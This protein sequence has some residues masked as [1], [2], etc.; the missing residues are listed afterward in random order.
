MVEQVLFTEDGQTGLT[1]VQILEQQKVV[2]AGEHLVIPPQALRQSLIHLVVRGRVEPERGLFEDSYHLSKSAH[3]EL[4]AL[5]SQSAQ[6]ID[7]VVGRLFQYAAEASSSYS[8]PFLDA[9]CRV[10][11]ILTETYVRVLIGKARPSDL[12]T[13]AMLDDVIAEVQ[14]THPG[15]EIGVFRAALTSFFTEEDP[16][17][18][19]IKWNLAQSYYLAKALGLDP[20]GKLLSMEVL[21]G[22]E[23]YLDTNIII[24][25]LEPRARHH[26]S[27]RALFSI[28]KR[29]GIPLCVCQ[30]SLDQ[31]RYVTAANVELLPRAAPQIPAATSAKVPSIFY[32]MYKEEL[33]ATGTVDFSI[34][35]EQFF[36]PIKPLRENCG[37]ELLDDNWFT[38]ASL[39]SQVEEAAEQLNENLVARKRLRKAQK[40]AIHDAL[41][42]LWITKQRSE[43]KT[44]CWLVTLDTSFSDTSWVPG[45]SGTF[46]LTL[47]ALLQWLSPLVPQEDSSFQTSYA[48]AVKQMVLPQDRIFE[49][50]D[51]LIFSDMA[52]EVGELPA[53]DVEACIRHLKRTV[54][55]VDTSTA[56]GRETLSHGVSSFFKD[57]GRKHKLEIT[58]LEAEK[59]ATQTEYDRKLSE[60]KGSGEEAIAE[61]VRLKSLGFEDQ[62]LISVLQENVAESQA[63]IAALEESLKSGK[64]AQEQ[65]RLRRSAAWRLLLSG[66]LLVVLE[67]L[68]VVAIQRVKPEKTLLDCIEVH[69]RI[70]AAVA[71]GCLFATKWILGR[72]RLQAI[73][74]PS[75]KDG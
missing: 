27:V 29:L 37:I 47:D 51:F 72:D 17:F 63:R 43:K 41:L 33:D 64:A 48:E 24:P 2:I 69:W 10:F 35:F 42:A 65:V 44:N 1:E 57:P 40:S 70:I 7:R 46:A 61:L 66:I 3:Q 68:L 55:A 74:W 18:A 39:Q 20:S 31:L 14:K 52:Y 30:I 38:D 15:I 26:K 54:P 22:A 34:L 19:A 9:L 73:G 53:E 59:K 49:L 58:R 6:L 50:N 23:F 71:I 4:D 12:T 11:S 21:T 45:F 62:K 32:R 75:R 16:D 25:A 28:C 8:R 36:A 13:P 56:A 67:I 5:Q 60:A